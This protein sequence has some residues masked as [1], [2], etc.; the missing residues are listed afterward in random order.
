MPK[1]IRL[2]IALTP[3]QTKIFDAIKRSGEN[4]MTRPALYAA[5]FAARVPAPKGY[6]TV[7]VHIHA[8]NFLLVDTD[9]Q[10][11]RSYNG[12]PYRLVPRFARRDLL[13]VA[14]R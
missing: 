13:R 14:S 8:L 10:I 2:G 9:W 3:L 5:V 6:S 1:N 4:G 12:A 11:S 7:S